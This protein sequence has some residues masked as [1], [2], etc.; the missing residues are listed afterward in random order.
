MLILVGLYLAAL[1][2][3]ALLRSA[4]EGNRPLG[5][6]SEARSS[7]A[8]NTGGRRPQRVFG[9]VAAVVAVI[10]CH[11]LSSAFRRDSPPVAETHNKQVLAGRVEANLDGYTSGFALSITAQLFDRV[12]PATE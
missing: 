3:W 12:D 9:A 10:V 11:R 1:D 7:E 5:T 2:R 6:L 4:R 8:G